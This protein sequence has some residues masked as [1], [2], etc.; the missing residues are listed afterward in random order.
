MAINNPFGWGSEQVSVAASGVRSALQAIHR[1]EEAMRA[2]APTVRKIGIADLREALAQGFED[3]KAYRT[4][5]IFLCVMYPIIG[6]VLYRMVI[7]QEMFQL[8]FPLASGFALIGPFVGIG[9][10]EMSRHREKGMTVGWATAFKV[11]RSP[12]MGAIAVLGL[13][14]TAVFLVWLFAAQAIFGMAF[15]PH[16]HPASIADF[17]NDVMTTSSGWMLIGAGMAVGFVF[18]LAVFALTVVSFPLLIDRDDIGLDVAL[19]TSLR[20]VAANPV[21]MAAWGLIIVAGL[22]LGSIPLFVGLAVVMPILGHATW[23][24]YRKVTA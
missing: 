5:V 22:V 4:D 14:L 23:H 1:P 12:S 20:A 8:L 21:T 24:L 7:G 3:F 15:G 10:Y 13:L 9:L 18:A 11:F 2:P 6:I 16:Y 17:A 19:G